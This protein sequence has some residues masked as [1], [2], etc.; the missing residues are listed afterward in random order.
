MTFFYR[1]RVKFGT[2]LVAS[3]CLF[4]AF[5][6][7]DTLDFTSLGLDPIYDTVVLPNATLKA[8]KPNNY[9]GTF[10]PT[11]PY[12]YGDTTGYGGICSKNRGC[13]GD[14]EI[15]FNDSIFGLSFQA[16]GYSPGDAFTITG[17]RGADLIGTYYLTSQTRIDLSTFGLL[18]RLYFDAEWIG[19]SSGM[20]FTEFDFTT[21]SSIPLPP[22]LPLFAGSLMGLL[23]LGRKRKSKK[24]PRN[25]RLKDFHQ[26]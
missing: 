20:V 4:S 7:S 10:Q 25:Q 24:Q 6:Q 2:V 5:S 16:N 15:T 21:M 14:M 9:P 12:T 18:D 8:I 3:I 17:Y 13:A 19:S 23:Y 11:A 26:I 22:A 1:Y